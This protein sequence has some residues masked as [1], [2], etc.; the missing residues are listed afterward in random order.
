MCGIAGI[1][2]VDGRIGPEQLQRIATA[3]GDALAHRGPDDA[4]A[5][6]D[7]TGR[8]ALAH[9][10]LSI[11][12]L[13]ERGR[14]PM[15][16]PDGLVGLAFN[17][18]V[19]NWR[20]LREDLEARGYVFAS[21]TDAE[22][23]LYLFASARP[24]NLARVEGMYAFATWNASTG[25][26]LLARDP[27][28]QK[29][30][31]LA[32]GDGWLAF[33][34]ELTAL[35]RIP[36][37][38]AR[39]D[40]EALAEYLLLQ[41]VHAPRTIYADCE[42][43]PPGGW[44]AVDVA[45]AAP[46]LHRGRHF[47]FEARGEHR[48]PSPYEP[49]P[50]ADLDAAAERLHPLLL[51]AVS[52][53]L[54]SD[55]PLGAF[56]SGGI[57]SALVVAM[58]TKELGV[59]VHTFS[60]GFEGTD[61][62]EHELA[63]EASRVL[64][65]EHHEQMLAPDAVD[66]LPRIAAALDEPLGDSSCLPT[67][68]LSEFTRGHV[69]VALSGDGGDELFGGYGR[70]RETLREDGDWRL[71]ARYLV[72]RRRAWRPG[73]AYCSGRWLMFEPDGVR[74]LAGAAAGEHA[75]AL[76][77]AWAAAVDRADRP[78]IHRMRQLDVG[79]YLPGAVLA[80]VDRMS[81]AFAL[82]VRCP[83]LDRDVARFASGLD[84]E[85]AY[86]DGLTKPL[87]RHLARRYL[88]EDAVVRPKMGFGL[89]GRAWT[90]E[91]ML[92]LCE[93]VLLAPDGRLADRLGVEGLRGFVEHQRRDGCFSIFQVWTVLVLEMWLRAHGVGSRAPSLAGAT[94]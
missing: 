10:R 21:Q 15:V 8:C 55:V 72:R 41:Y 45:G 4:G 74:S 12:D 46:V 53:R 52:R 89:P 32:R 63:R 94:A 34:S 56:L 65:T 62:S 81:M 18:E 91:Q 59:P 35:L 64:G 16:T 17:G 3:M 24:D 87:L 31:Y 77:A 1:I 50:T 30:L 28:G 13:S 83:L 73:P 88:P 93:D 42:K 58:M 7:P 76:V 75:E 9:R 86:Q 11:L 37:F 66:L 2:D 39:V 27:F 14:Q 49:L 29:P 67:Y 57:D 33:A 51:Q 6:V 80:K 44:V 70:Y 61:E 20:E 48:A 82:E 85:L 84:A 90:S 43:V 47:D 68:L 69:T 71:R 40:D 25:R 60:I 79:T 19:Y 26:L 36:G 38:E 5:W 22:A 78:L 23:L 54:M 92:G